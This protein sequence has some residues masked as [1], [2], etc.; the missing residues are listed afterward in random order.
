MRTSFQRITIRGSIPSSRKSA[1]SP[2]RRIRSPSSSNCLSCSTS[3]SWTPTNPLRLSQATT[4]RSQA[5]TR[6]AVCCTACLVGELDA[7]QAEQVGGLLQLV[8]DVVDLDR[9]HVDVV[10]VERRQCVFRSVIRSCVTPSPAVSAAFTCSWVMP[11]FGV[12]GEIDDGARPAS[13][14]GRRSGSA[15]ARLDGIAWAGA[16]PAVLVPQLRRF[17]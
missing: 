8:D 13:A 11:E 7:V 3:A 4:R 15:A 5:E 6:S 10:P 17:R 16:A 14:R 1:A 9:E 12:L 2:S